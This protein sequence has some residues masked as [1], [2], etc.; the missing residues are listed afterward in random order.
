ML[1]SQNKLTSLSDNGGA[2]GMNKSIWKPRDEAV[3][4]LVFLMP[5]PGELNKQTQT[6]TVLSNLN[7]LFGSTSRGK[8]KLRV[9]IFLRPLL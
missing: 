6:N 4:D 2:R 9:F 3:L 8:F 1:Q 7:F 5:A